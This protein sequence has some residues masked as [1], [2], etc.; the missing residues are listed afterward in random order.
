MV[1]ICERVIIL[2]V[3]ETKN[4]SLVLWERK[5]LNLSGIQDVLSFDELSVYLITAQGN[6]LIEGADLHIKVLDVS[7]GYMTIEGSSRSMIYNDK[8][9]K[10]KDG[11]FAKMLK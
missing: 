9:T 3:I 5:K 8:E 11:F 4:A 6:L 7:S 10:K 2:E 1:T